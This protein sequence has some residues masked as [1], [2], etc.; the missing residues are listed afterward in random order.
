M[1]FGVRFFPD[2]RPGERSAK[3]CFRE[4]LDIAEEADRLGF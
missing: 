4:A 1:R 2:P 3:W